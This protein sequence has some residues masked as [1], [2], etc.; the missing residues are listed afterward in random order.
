MYLGH[1]I[2]VY[3]GAHAAII[4]R[5]QRRPLRNIWQHL[6]PKT[7]LF[8]LPECYFHKTQPRLAYC[9]V[10]VTELKSGFQ[11]RKGKFYSSPADGAREQKESPINP[12]CNSLATF[13]LLPLGDTIYGI[14]IKQMLRSIA[15]SSV[16]LVPLCNKA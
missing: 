12:P 10:P 9:S 16:L 14:I 6:L 11:V 4:L 1:L 13:S 7:H 15:H 3:P 8:P 5:Q 2:L